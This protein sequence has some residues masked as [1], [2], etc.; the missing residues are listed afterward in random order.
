ME[1]ERKKKITA[2]EA[3][4]LDIIFLI[5][6]S[7]SMSIE[8]E[9]VKKSCVDF[10]DRII[11][12]K[13]NVQLGLIGFDIGGHRSGN[14]KTNY[15]VCQLSRYTIGVWKL[16]SPM[17]FKEN[18]K[19]LSI[20]LFGGAGCYIADKDSVDIFPH[21]AS[22]Y[23]DNNHSRIL[24]LISDEMGKTDGISDIVKLL[25]G[26]DIETYVMGV[27]DPKGAH[28]SIARLTGGKF[29]DIRASRG[30]QD[31]SELLSNAADE[32]VNSISQ[33]M[34][35]A[36]LSEES[37]EKLTGTPN[38]SPKFSFGEIKRPSFTFGQSHK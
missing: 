35:D 12:E 2:N 9:A 38:D 5:D 6:T 34:R 32:I 16:S 8:L 1:F 25:N 36:G 13:K 18:I 28:E 4:N 30:T 27:S 15:Q 37:I 19:T 17:V 23:I 24:V 22:S 20:G 31:F 26:H 7:G 3:K 21:V 11:K 10:A 14:V 33:K 29:W